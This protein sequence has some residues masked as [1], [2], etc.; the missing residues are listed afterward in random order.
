MTPPLS[1]CL[2]LDLVED[3]HVSDFVAGD[4]DPDSTSASPLIFYAIDG[5]VRI[6]LTK[7]PSGEIQIDF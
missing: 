4:V 3:L 1:A 6:W 5:P 7:R 2:P